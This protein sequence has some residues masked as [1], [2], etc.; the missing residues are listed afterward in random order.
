MHSSVTI[1][2][3]RLP[4]AVLALGLLALAPPV[5]RAS[6]EIF[7]ITTSNALVNFNSGNP[8][9]FSSRPITGMQPGEDALGIDFRPAPPGGRLYLLG[10]TGRLYRIDDPFGGIAVAVAGP[11]ATTLNGTHTGFDFNPAVD[12]IRVIN[13]ADQNLRLHPDTGVLAATD[14]PLAFQVG[15]INEGVNPNCSGAAYDNNMAGTPST[16][17]YNIDHALDILVT[18]V[19]ANSG[20]LQTVG[21][22]GVDVNGVNGFDISGFTGIAYAALNTGTAQSTLYVLNLATGSASPMGVIGCLEPIRGLSVYREVPTPV[23]HS[24]WSGVKTL[25]DN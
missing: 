3:F 25:I 9:F 17:L 16:T 2:G 4:A 8:W 19:P 18:Q 12:R 23:Q 20:L 21:S 7:A 11:I 15:D 14:T 10:S 13:D 22:L 6:E 5:V 24:T 1:S